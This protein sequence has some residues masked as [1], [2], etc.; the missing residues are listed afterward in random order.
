MPRSDHPTRH[1]EQAD[2]A[3]SSYAPLHDA[4]P[5]SVS[6]T[7][8]AEVIDLSPDASIDLSSASGFPRPQGAADPAALSL[9]GVIPVPPVATE[10][11][12][13]DSVYVRRLKPAVDRLIAAVL[14]VILFPLLLLIALG[15]LATLRR[16]ILF[17]QVRVGRHGVPFVLWKFRTMRPDRRTRDLPVA[18]E[19][20]VCHK[21]RHD[22]RHTRFGRSL[23]CTRLDE[24][25]Q[26]VNVL[27]GDMSLV[28]PRPELIEIVSR[29]EP[30]QHARHVVRPGITGLWQVS[31]IGDG[32]M[33][34]NTDIDL[35]YI[36][37]MDLRTDLRILL[38]TP[39]AAV[40]RRG[41]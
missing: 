32:M 19:R 2:T 31:A 29:Y 4:D 16:P 26:L 12:Q 3:T 27:V 28:G 37:A 17:R 41:S 9:A 25:P 6:L 40:L 33:H 20:R 7:G 34:E 38:R 14:L 5:H 10:A 35:E 13:T 30:W 24:L 21:S 23:R 22:P 36:R 8:P 39:V 18:V 15:L 11:I 1:A